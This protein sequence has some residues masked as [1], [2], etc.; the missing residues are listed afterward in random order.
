MISK[1]KL[2]SMALLGAVL[3]AT[4]LLLIL[5]PGS[6]PD[7]SG[8]RSGQAPT[9]EGMVSGAEIPEQAVVEPG[10]VGIPEGERQALVQERQVE[11]SITG[12]ILF[13]PRVA[14]TGAVVLAYHGKPGDK[15]GAFSN[16]MSTLG[17]IGSSGQPDFS[18][19]VSGEPLDR[20]SVV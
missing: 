16:L 9:V 14:I 4:A 6:P 11:T 19:R 5:D 7:S 17:Q 8:P 2:L 20:K 15:K 18:M 1:T 3:M 10:E 13:D 12:R